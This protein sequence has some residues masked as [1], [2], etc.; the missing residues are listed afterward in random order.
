M[1]VP[2]SW[3]RDF[4][5]FDGTPSELAATLDDLGLVVEAVEMIGEGL[6]DV[7]VSRVLE[8][9][10]IEGADK[11]RRVLVDHGDGTVEVACGANNFA[12]GDLVPL[13][14]VGAVLPGGFTIGQRKMRGMVSNGMLCSGREL[15]LSDDHGG[16]LILEEGPTVVPGAPLMTALGLTRDVVFDVTVEAN[17]PDAWCIAG[18]ARDLAAR[19]GLPFSEPAPVEPA[20]SLRAGRPVDE[21]ISVRVEDSELCPR[22][23]AWAVEGV[24]VTDSPEWLARRLTLAGMRPINNV[25]DASNYVMLEWGQPSHPYD[26]DRLPG[27]G[28]LVRRAGAGETITTLD[29]V[30]RTLGRPGPGL[31]DTGQDCLIADAEGTGV[32]IAGIMGG[33]S[34]QIDESTTRVLLEVAYFVPMAIAR[35]SKR[36][37]LRTEASARFERGCDPSGIDRAA[38]RFFELLSLTAG[39]ECVLAT[40]KVDHR[41]D[42]PEPVRLPVRTSQINALLGTGFGSDEV[43]ELLAPLGIVA[44]GAS[45]DPTVPL[46]VTVPTYRPDIRPAPMGEADIAEEVARTYGYSR[47]PRRSP[48]WPQP[49]RLSARQRDRRFVKEVL[50]GLGASEAWTPAFVTDADQMSAGVAPPY[51]A[52]ANPLVE[53]ERYLRASMAP[54]LLRALAY[55]LERRQGA[56]RF[57]EV[58]KV[59]APGVP[60]ADGDPVASEGVDRVIETERVSMILAGDEDDAFAAVGAW[61]TLADALRLDDVRLVQNAGDGPCEGE[62]LHPHRK[63]IVVTGPEDA[64][65]VVGVLGEIHPALAQS[66]G[67]VAP[68]GRPR[69]LGWLDLDLGVLLDH[70]QVARRTVEARPVSRFPSSDIDL[71]FVVPESVAA[72]DVLDTLRTLG[73]DLLESVT[74]FDVFRGASMAEGERSLA[75]RLR[76]CSQE[77]T[78]TDEEIAG[79][80]TVCIDEVGRRHG[81]RLR[82]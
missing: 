4:A 67:V 16:L 40:G 30:T 36:L 70:D 25:V 49:G 7:V 15:E 55:N 79:Q 8:I 38:E 71:A 59:F 12:V 11:I 69:S 39:E 48:S 17:R 43:V 19:L 60:D 68:D 54:G 65:T 45:D 52:V 82:Q 24:R 61:Q 22:F 2:L 53:A 34:S 63:A 32:G 21:V 80:R 18:V 28:L 76:F 58:G 20:S 66:F 50:A 26:L 14:P 46:E 23:A 57:F 56:L 37:V 29:G 75:F 73:G 35:T 1:R 3:L 47:L 62:V 51:V 13:A 27:G 31:G 33:A 9:T 42:V 5:P 6:E 72:G 10:A 78:L 81:A 41:R 74:L 77:G 44:D 64:T